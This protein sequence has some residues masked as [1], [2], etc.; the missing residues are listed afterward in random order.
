[1]HS[2]IDTY[3]LIGASEVCVTVG[4]STTGL[5]ALAFGKPLIEVRLPDQDYS[6]SSLGVAEPSSGFEDMGSKIEAILTQGLTPARSANVE[7]YLA[8]NFAYRD[9]EALTRIADLVGA[10]L[11]AKAEAARPPLSASGATR[12]PCSIILPVEDAPLEAVLATLEGIAA[13]TAGELYE[14]LIVNCASR[15]E[16]RELL[17]ALDGDV[18]V[19]P[20]EPGWSYA[21]ACNRAVAE[22]EGKYLVFLKPGL[23]PSQ[24]WLAGLIQAAEDKSDSGVVGGQL[25]HPNGLLWHI[26][27]AFDVNQS[28]F[29]IYRFLQREFWG[30]QKQREFKAVEFPFLLPRELFC[31]LGGFNTALHNRFEDIDFCLRVKKEGRRVLYTPESTS[32]LQS[33]SWRPNPVQEQANR[34]RFYSTWTGMLWQDDGLY[35]K[36]DGLTHDTLSLLYRELAQRVAHGAKQS[37][38]SIGA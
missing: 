11:Q 31:R 9:G 19:I 18:K 26:G 8:D 1:V 14:V 4:N 15:P 2:N 7:K 21:A 10:A 13:H 24:D 12:I 38:L 23:V 29:S 5:E 16:T 22:T 37:E 6:Y 33:T 27:V 32:I 17:A 35:L 34:I 30:A 25:L 28:P 3:A 20:G 36:E